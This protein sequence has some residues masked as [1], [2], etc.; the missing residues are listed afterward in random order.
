MGIIDDSKKLLGNFID[1]MTEVELRK[2][3]IV[4]GSGHRVVEIEREIEKMEKV[5]LKMHDEIEVDL[6]GLEVKSVKKYVT[7]P[8]IRRKM[9]AYETKL[10]ELNQLK[11]SKEQEKNAFFFND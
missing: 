10:I 11:L 4:E 2:K 3:D 8:N 6:K 9:N 5:V 1:T 7:N